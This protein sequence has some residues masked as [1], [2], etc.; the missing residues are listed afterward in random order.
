M[1]YGHTIPFC[2]TR[3]QSSK[4]KFEFTGLIKFS[5][6]LYIYI[7]IQAETYN[8]EKLLLNA[9]SAIFQ[10]YY[11]ENKSI[12]SEK[13]MTSHL[14]KTNTLSWFFYGASSLKQQSMDVYTVVW[15]SVVHYYCNMLHCTFQRCMT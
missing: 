2:F 3:R 13:I 1:H 9:N 15:V 5:N 14:Y 10:L 11:C 6:L 8:S 7:Y 12:F 4:W